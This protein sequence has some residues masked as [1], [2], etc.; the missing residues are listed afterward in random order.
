MLCWACLCKFSILLCF[1]PMKKELSFVKVNV[2]EDCRQARQGQKGKASHSLYNN[3]W[4]S[5]WKLRNWEKGECGD[6]AERALLSKQTTIAHRENNSMRGRGKT[7][8]KAL[9]KRL[10]ATQYTVVLATIGKIAQLAEVTKRK[11]SVK[12]ALYQ[13]YLFLRLKNSTTLSSR[14][15]WQNCNITITIM[16]TPFCKSVQLSVA[17]CKQNLKLF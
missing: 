10:V 1:Y 11:L 3:S 5:N 14:K 13:K 17:F 12:M 6:W 7:A 16:S 15:F 2:E 8:A 9:Y 4:L